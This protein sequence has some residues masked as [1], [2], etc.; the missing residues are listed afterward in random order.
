MVKISSKPNVRGIKKVSEDIDYRAK[1][2]G[3]EGRLWT[4]LSYT[5]VKGF[6][7]GVGLAVTLVVIIPFLANLL[8]F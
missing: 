2:I 3:R 6:G 5:R 1:L 7:M 8:G 4:A